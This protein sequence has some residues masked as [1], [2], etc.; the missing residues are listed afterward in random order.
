MIDLGDYG[1]PPST[2]RRD[3]PLVLL[4]LMQR[5]RLELL[6]LLTIAVLINSDVV[7]RG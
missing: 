4:Q 2:R 5:M 3:Y 7:P 6:L 1:H